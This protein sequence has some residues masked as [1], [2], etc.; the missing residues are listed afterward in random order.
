M[1]VE[2]VSRKELKDMKKDIKYFI[3]I[4]TFCIFAVKSYSQLSFS[5]D[6]LKISDVFWLC[7][8]NVWI[9]DF[10]YGPC[11]NMFFSI[12]NDGHDTV[13][14]R[15]DVIKLYLEYGRK[16]SRKKKEPILNFPETETILIIPPNSSVDFW[17]QVFFYEMNGEISTEMN[18]RFVNFLPDITKIIESA[19]VVI[20]IPG[21]EIMKASFKNCFTGNT[22]FHD[23]TFRESI[24]H[25]RD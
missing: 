8:K 6:T 16:M 9:E 25:Y 20:A 10:A 14:I 12:K 7:E 22:F 13:S 3:T 1:D 11:F 21:F 23:G 19:K 4:L 2:I 15:Y 5:I 18:Y 24:F 17:G